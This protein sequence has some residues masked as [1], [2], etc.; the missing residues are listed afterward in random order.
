MS[1]F[2]AMANA[3]HTF[4]AWAEKTLEK[5]YNEAPKIEQIAGTVLTYVGPALQT[6]VTAY[7]GTPTGAIVGK[8]IGQAQS[9][10]TAASGLIY[11]FGPHPSVSSI[12]SSVQTN[13]SALLTA[14]HVTST[15]S[16]DAVNKVNNELNVLVAAIGKAI[17][18]APAAIGSAPLTP[19]PAV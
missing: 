5:M 2:S 17:S 10:L 1:F 3:E 18:P 13:L 15:K 12:I 11:D 9:D 7:A 8:V 19:E 4:A 6:V 14:G 16:V